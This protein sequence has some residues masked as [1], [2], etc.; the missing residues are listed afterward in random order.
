MKKIGH[1]Y[2]H[3]CFV[4]AKGYNALYVVYEIFELH[5][6]L[7]SEE[8]E[9][10]GRLGRCLHPF[11]NNNNNNN[12]NYNNNNILNLKRVTHLVTN[13]SSMRPSN[14]YIYTVLHSV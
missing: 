5:G 12:N 2:F 4:F 1:L 9:F 7:V 3:F 10:H 14:K 11:N 13:K 6:W 8:I